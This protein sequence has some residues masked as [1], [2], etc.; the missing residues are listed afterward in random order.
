M[1][2]RD[3]QPGDLLIASPVLTDGVFDQTVVLLLD[4]D[5]DGSLGVIV[6]QASMTALDAVLPE[7]TSVVCD[8]QVLFHGGPVSPNGAVCLAAVADPS[9]EPPGWRRVF[10]NIGLLH[11]DTPLEIVSGAYTHLRI[12]AGYAGWAPGQLRGELAKDMWFPVPARHDDVFGAEPYDLW[13]R[14]LRRQPGEL[15]WLSTWTEDPEQN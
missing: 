5:A 15:A 2:D 13:R 6:N 4:A 9:E 10:E 3:P 12:F 7:W 14:A 8:P 11:L 1:P